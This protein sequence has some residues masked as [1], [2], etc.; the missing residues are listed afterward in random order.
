MDNFNDFI[1]QLDIVDHSNEEIFITKN[2]TRVP[3]HQVIQDL[4]NEKSI[5]FEPDPMTV[6]PNSLR[7]LVG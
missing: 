4:I 7:C 6:I 1:D 3:K 2:G 5:N